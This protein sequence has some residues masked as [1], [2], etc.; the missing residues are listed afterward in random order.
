MNGIK[1]LLDTNFIIGLIKR[2]EPVI[3][4]LAASSIALDECAYSFITRIELLSYPAITQP[5]IESIESI[6]AT[7]HYVSTSKEI[8]NTTIRLRRQYR[9][10]TPDAIVA[11]TAIALNLELLTL[12][13]QLAKQMQAILVQENNP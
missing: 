13:Q 12:D 9:L 2:T 11:A 7:M 6:L 5:E 1:L 4:I 3:K 8:E 10:K